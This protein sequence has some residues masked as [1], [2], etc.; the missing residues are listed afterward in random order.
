MHDIH[1]SQFDVEAVQFHQIRH[2]SAIFP[3]NFASVA[4][5]LHMLQAKLGHELRPGF[6]PKVC[7]KFY[8]Q[9]QFE[10]SFVV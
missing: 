9:Q 10:L 4:S 1:W 7:L 6:L 5:R 2:Q 8:R 3:P